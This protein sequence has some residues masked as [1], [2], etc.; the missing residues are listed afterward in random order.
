MNT[1]KAALGFVALLGLLISAAPSS[2][3]LSY[4]ELTLT[5]PRIIS[6]HPLSIS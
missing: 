1:L 4:F 3:A 6:Y 2:P 5:S